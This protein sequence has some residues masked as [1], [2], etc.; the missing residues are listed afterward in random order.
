MSSASAPNTAVAMTRELP[1][2][3]AIPACIWN[4]LSFR[5]ER[6]MINNNNQRVA[7]GTL[8]GLR[9]IAHRQ[10]YDQDEKKDCRQKNCFRIQRVFDLLSQVRLSLYQ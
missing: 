3:V 5:P 9:F 7:R 4:L 2:I 1:A 8:Y 6:R 10:V